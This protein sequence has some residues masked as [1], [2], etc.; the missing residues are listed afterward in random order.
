METDGPAVG[1]HDGVLLFPKGTRFSPVKRVRALT[2]LADN[3]QW[4][5]LARAQ[6]LQHA[7]PPR[8]AFA[9]TAAGVGDS[10]RCTTT[11]DRV[12][13]RVDAGQPSSA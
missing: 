12:L 13:P 1:E 11:A 3:K 6:R 10:R 5:R 7:L 9:A 2:R 4:V 8:C